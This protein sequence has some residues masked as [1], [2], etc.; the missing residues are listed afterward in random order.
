MTLI[1]LPMMLLLAFQTVSDLRQSE[2]LEQAHHFATAYRGVVQ[3][4]KIFLNGVVDAVDTGQLGEDAIRELAEATVSIK[5]LSRK[6]PAR[7]LGS[8]LTKMESINSSLSRDRSLNALL[9]LKSAIN[10]LNAELE[11]G[12][13]QYEKQT[14]Q[15]IESSIKSAKNRGIAVSVA[16][17]ITILLTSGFICLMVSNVVTP[18]TNLA[19]L[20]ERVA[21]GDLNVEVVQNSS[22]EIGQLSSC[23]RRMTDHLRQTIR[24]VSET[25]AQVASAANH[26]L[27]ASVQ[28]ASGAEE[29]AAQAGT[30]ATASEE[31]AAT[32]SEIAYNCA[33]VAQGS[34]QANDTALEGAGVVQETIAG[35]NQIAQRV[36]SSASTVNAL[37]ERSDQIGAI[38][39][40]IEDIA[41]Q[42]NLLALNAAIEAARAGE[43]GRGFAVVADEVR[44]L[45]ERTTR[46]T[47]EI[48]DMIKA[49]QQETKG[50][51]AS[52]EE[53]VREVEKG[54]AKAARSGESL[55]EILKQINAVTTQVNQITVAAEEQTAT[56]S[57]ISNNVQQI[58]LI[59]Q[60]TARGAQESASDAN[61]LANLAEELRTLVGQ[62]KLEV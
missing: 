11:N 55:Q 50:A 47:K 10:Q 44:A 40:T 6:Y 58:T 57:E 53:G 37:G 51:V 4:F 5:D 30:V 33:T 39:G 17:G 2:K 54:T 56:T 25:S 43:Q 46:A 14:D 52:M 7:D 34:R 18:I 16:I 20:A 59:V 28:M 9:P 29:V 38:I 19:T 15:V 45:A 61:H 12:G 60:Q 27:S 13:K 35:M 42:T 24:K 8:V 21:D 26:L 41:D 36:R 3:K 1:L 62:F 32:S 48:S 23:F 49:I 22:D 31:M